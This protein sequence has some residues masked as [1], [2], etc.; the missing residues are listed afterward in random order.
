MAAKPRVMVFFFKEHPQLLPEEDL[1][2]RFDFKAGHSCLV[3]KQPAGE[4]DPPTVKNLWYRLVVEE[5][6]SHGFWFPEKAKQQI[7]EM[8]D[9]VK[10]EAA[11]S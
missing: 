5:G 10:K 4:I 8:Q 1:F 6:I 3:M 7:R 2:H 11:S 9:I